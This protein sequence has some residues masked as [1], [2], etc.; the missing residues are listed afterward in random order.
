MSTGRKTHWQQVYTEKEPTAVSWFQPVAEKSLQLIHSTG[1]ARHQSILD[2]GG[3]A[4]AL[5]DHLLEEGYSDVSVLDISGSALER[6]RARLGQRA[7]QASWIETDVTGFEPQRN[8]A[9]WH[10][11]ALFHFLTEPI[12]RDRYINVLR[13]ALQPAGYVV[14]ATF[15]P[16][17]PKRC[18][19]L[20]ICRYGIEQLDDMLGADFALRYHE[21][22]EH[23]TPTGSIQQFLYSVWQASP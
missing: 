13:R 22:N 8:Y 3:G 10:D 5:V 4:S 11:R 21:L 17:G 2:A 12:D 18:S 9:L 20:D 15:G 1:I 14:M 7:G 19:G 23:R 16:E 6:S